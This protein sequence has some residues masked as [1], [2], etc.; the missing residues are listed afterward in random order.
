MIYI[1]FTESLSE[2]ELKLVN[3]LTKRECSIEVVDKGTSSS[4]YDFDV[5]LPEGM[6]DGE[7]T[8]ELI[9][10]GKTVSRGLCQIG[11]Y[12]ADKKQYNKEEKYVTYNG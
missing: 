6:V 9:K 10:N 2:M 5:V 11:N 1:Y 12:I 8:Y 4:F 7:Y 3:N